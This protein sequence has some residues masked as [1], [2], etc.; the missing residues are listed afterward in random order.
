MSKKNLC[1]FCYSRLT[2][3]F[4]DM[5]KM[6][7]AN[8]LLKKKNYKTFKMKTM[9]CK[10][11]FLVQNI[12]SVNTNKIFN[13][14]YPYFSSVSS[15]WLEHAK[16]FTNSTI[17]KFK[18]DEKNKILEIASNDGYL[19]QYFKKKNYECLGVE[20]SASVANFA[21]KKGINTEKIF[22]TEKNSEKL[23]N[24]YGDFD[25]VI[26]NNVIAHVPDV[27]DFV[28]GIKKIL[29]IN[30]IV[31]IEF[32]YILNLIKN[33]Q[34]D[35]IYHEHYS[36]YSL[37]VIKNI[38]EKNKLVVFDVQEL[39]THGGSLRV[40]A[41]NSNCKK[42][43]I[44]DTV[45]RILMKESRIGLNKFKIYSNAGKNFH[46][47]INKFKKFIKENTLKNKV[48]LGYGAAAKSTVLINVSKL[49]SNKYF[50]FVIDKATSKQ[51]KF[52]PN[53]NIRIKD[54]KILKHN[55]DFLVIFPW[56]IKNEIISQ[57]KKYKNIKNFVTAI[58]R[59]KIIKNS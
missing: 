51:N 10:K 22:F 27:N 29:S 50:K 44:K 4:F 20:P 24:K 54:M 39:S 45:K 36:Y 56:N 26:A 38:L 14:N 9:V 52:I 58:P 19:L 6:P 53:S 35:T 5:G 37:N 16:N 2:N 3:V 40:F 23:K 12:D 48:I 7:I 17:K 15:S 49:N 47:T 34:F 33:N 18:L 55:I 42:F 31:S 11:C 25:L 32:A 43:K 59:L 13:S 57:L 41:K 46:T 28:K 21:L 8:D 1:R 30:G